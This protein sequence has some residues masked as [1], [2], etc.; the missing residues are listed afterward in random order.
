VPVSR[1]RSN[2]VVRLHMDS[3][4][5]LTRWRDRA[6]IDAWDARISLGYDGLGT[7][8]LPQVTIATAS[9]LMVDSD[10]CRDYILELSEIS[11]DHSLI[12]GALLESFEDEFD[13]LP[14]ADGGRFLIAED[15]VVDRFWRG[16]QIGPSLLARATEVLRPDV[17][18]LSP[19]ALPTRVT[20]YGLCVSDYDL[21]REGPRAQRKVE[22]A[23]R[24]AGFLPLRDGV[25]WLGGWQADQAEAMGRLTQIEISARQ[26][27][28]RAWW[29]RRAKRVLSAS[30]REP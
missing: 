30:L 4:V 22:R 14:L 9:L 13:E 15:V 19:S 24:K 2:P 28:V 3:D 26:P 1:T 8:Q 23:W 6:G 27:H 7:W 16:G 20:A 21:P 18:L 11:Y 25:Y 12:A 29:R 5:S 10:A 17:V